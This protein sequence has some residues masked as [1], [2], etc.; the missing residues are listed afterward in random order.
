LRAEGKPA[1]ALAAGE[2]VVASRASLG[3][4]HPSVKRG[5]V[6]AVEAALDIGD[7]AKADELL[8]IVQSARPGQVTLF[9][10][11]HAAR[12]AARLAGRRGEIDSVEPGF[13]AAEQGFRDL[14]NPFGLGV[15]LLEHG[16]WMAGQGRVDE[17]LPLLAEARDI[18]E[19]LEASPWVER[20]DRTARLANVTA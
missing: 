18:F 11:A 12:L 5:L 16:E 1:E 6:E 19:R 8:A 20:L 3:L 2:E 4:T 9:L 17:A 15:T 14:G 10:R 13:L 7:T